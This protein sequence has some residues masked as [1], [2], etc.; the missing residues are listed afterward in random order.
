MHTASEEGFWISAVIFGS[1]S[2][3]TYFIQP[4]KHQQIIIGPRHDFYRD[5]WMDEH[6]IPSPPIIKSRIIGHFIKCQIII[7]SW[8]LKV[9]FVYLWHAVILRVL[10]FS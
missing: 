5:G 9:K 6:F 4:P 2:C 1:V 8:T 10:S 7:I 3:I